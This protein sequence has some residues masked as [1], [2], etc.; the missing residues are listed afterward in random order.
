MKGRS[1]WAGKSLTT[2]PSARDVEP[3]LRRESCPGKMG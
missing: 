3:Q 1:G 2:D